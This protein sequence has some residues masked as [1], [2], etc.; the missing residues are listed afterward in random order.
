[1]AIEMGKADSYSSLFWL[2]VSGLICFHALQLGVGTLS[3][4]GSGFVFIFSGLVIGIFSLMNFVLSIRGKNEGAFSPFKNVHWGKLMLDLGYILLYGV[5]L[6]RLGFLLSTF[7][8]LGLLLRTIE[9]K[10]WYV[11][12]LVALGGAG[13]TYGIFELW[14]HS[15]LPRGVFGF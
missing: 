9:S 10:R 5:L 8:L 3:D 4:P 13:G 6:E 7:L 1:M 11:I 12:L 2:V 15:R 14:L